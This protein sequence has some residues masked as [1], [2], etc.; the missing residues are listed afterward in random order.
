MIQV[1]FV[2]HSLI[3]T[4]HYANRD[5]AEEIERGRAD[6]CARAEVARFEVVAADF[7][8]RQQDFGRRGT[9]NAPI[10][11]PRFLACRK[12][13]KKQLHTE[14]H[15]RQVGDGLVPNPHQNDG[16]LA[17][18]SLDD[19]LAFLRGDHFDGGHESKVVHAMSRQFCE[20]LDDIENLR[21]CPTDAEQLIPV[22]TKGDILQVLLLRHTCRPLSIRRRRG[23]ASQPSR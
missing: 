18:R 2:H 5:D 19:D 9:L 12:G 10:R 13:T 3:R 14:C 1:F 7:D 23:R 20:A 4:Y 16:L 22:T 21:I 11:K 8:D 6:D 15:E 17:A